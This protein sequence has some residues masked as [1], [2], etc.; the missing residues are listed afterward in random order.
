LF[1]GNPVGNKKNSLILT[2]QKAGFFSNTIISKP[3][4]VTYK[5]SVICYV[6]QKFFG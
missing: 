1:P 2:R 5:L 6:L 3:S 4:N